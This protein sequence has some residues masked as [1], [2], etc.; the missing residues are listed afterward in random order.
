MMIGMQL[1][2][3]KGPDKSGLAWAQSESSPA[4]PG[5][6]DISDIVWA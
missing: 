4:G 5:T 2:V 1:E 3:S 6:V